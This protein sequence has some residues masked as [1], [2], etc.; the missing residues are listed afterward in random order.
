MYLILHRLFKFETKISLPGCSNGNGEDKKFTTN[1]HS[2]AGGDGIVKNGYTVV[3]G[4][5]SGDSEDSDMFEVK[6]IEH[7]RQVNRFPLIF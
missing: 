1:G 5:A 6:W 2:P 7:P 3:N 4:A